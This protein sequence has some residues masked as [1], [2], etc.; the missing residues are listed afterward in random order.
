MTQETPTPAELVCLLLDALPCMEL[1]ERVAPHL[2]NL[3]PLLPMLAKWAE[4]EQDLAAARAAPA[5]LQAT[6]HKAVFTHLAQTH[7]GTEALWGALAHE[8]RR[9]HPIQTTSVD[10][11]RKAGLRPKASHSEDD[12]LELRRQL[13]Y[14]QRL[15]NASPHGP[16]RLSE[17]IADRCGISCHHGAY[18]AFKSG[19]FLRELEEN[20]W[21]TISAARVS[22]LV[23][24]LEL[25]QG[26]EQR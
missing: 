4:V 5:H 24:A 14:G 17:L 22:E 13:E 20:G 16:L 18:A 10:E 15:V 2:P 21:P 3:R 6:F 26:E 12:R 7:G 23:V 8:M 25:L 11:A 19:R 9:R 1:I